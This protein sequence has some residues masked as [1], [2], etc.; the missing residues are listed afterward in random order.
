[1]NQSEF[2]GIGKVGKVSIQV[3]L[4]TILILTPCSFTGIKSSIFN[5]PGSHSTN[6]VFMFNQP[7]GIGSYVND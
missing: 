6:Q 1:M 7:G 3:W 2:H 4:Y 5:Q